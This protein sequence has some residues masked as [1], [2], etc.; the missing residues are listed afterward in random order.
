MQA[1]S[2]LQTAAVGKVRSILDVS[3][4]QPA[5][6]GRRVGHLAKMPVRAH[7]TRRR[8]LVARVMTFFLK[9]NLRIA[10]GR[11]VIAAL[12][13]DR[14]LLFIIGALVISNAYRDLSLPRSVR[15]QCL[16]VVVRLIDG[17]GILAR[18]RIDGHGGEPVPGQVIRRHGLPFSAGR[19]QIHGQ[20]RAA[21]RRKPKAVAQLMP[22]IGIR[23]RGMP[24]GS[25]RLRVRLLPIML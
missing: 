22:G 4:L 21:I 12:D 13:R 20:Q 23:S 15:P 6:Y 5:L 9:M 14:D 19:V 10:E 24:G 17:E 18:L 7:R 8:R 2:L 11:Q 1:L 3:G 25:S 16:H